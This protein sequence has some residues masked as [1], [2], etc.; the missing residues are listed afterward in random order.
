MTFYRTQSAVGVSMSPLDKAIDDTPAALCVL[1]HRHER[2]T[3]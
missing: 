1:R 3:E 2:R